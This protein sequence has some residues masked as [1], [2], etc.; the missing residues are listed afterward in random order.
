MGEEERNLGLGGESLSD[1]I[2]LCYLYSDDEERTRTMAR[3]LSRGL[4]DGEKVLCIRDSEAPHLIDVELAQLG[5]LNERNREAFS[6]AE[7]DESYC[8]GGDFDPDALLAGVG[9]FC[10]QARDEGFTGARISGDM[11]WAVRSATPTRALLEYEVKV[12]EF[13]RACPFVAICEYDARKMDGAQLMDIL[14]VHP[15][16]IVGGQVMSNPYFEAPRQALDK[17]LGRD[18]QA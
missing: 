16:V 13:L 10:S 17:M 18:A 12:T 5:A 7:N 6:T 11:S 3:F 15:A 2:H 4:T 9:D 14:R 1:G 8:P